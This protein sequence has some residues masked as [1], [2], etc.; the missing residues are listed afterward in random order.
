MES[1]S[2]MF[3][4]DSNEEYSSYDGSSSEEEKVMIPSEAKSIIKDY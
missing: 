4:L 3:L 2:D 1:S